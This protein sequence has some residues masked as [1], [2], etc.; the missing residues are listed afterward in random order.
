MPWAFIATSM[1]P[2]AMPMAKPAAM[3]M[4]S[5]GARI[6]PK[7][8]RQNRK[9]VTAVSLALRGTLLRRVGHM[10]G[11]ADIIAVYTVASGTAEDIELLSRVTA[12]E[13][14][15]A[16]YDVKIM[17]F[18]AQY[19]RQYSQAYALWKDP[20]YLAAATSSAASTPSRKYTMK[21]AARGTTGRRP[22]A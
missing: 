15:Q 19:L 18:Q 5:D 7:K 1:L 17:S 20:K 6:G 12:L 8:A 14:K 13:A 22:S 11:T 9:P 21:A 4:G 10:L 16:P 2:I 3:K